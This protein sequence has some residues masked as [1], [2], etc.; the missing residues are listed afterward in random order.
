MQSRD[1][2]SSYDRLFVVLPL[3]AV[4]ACVPSR[5]LRARIGLV[6]AF[7]I[8]AAAALQAVRDARRRTTEQL[9]YAWL[10]PQLARLPAAC[11]LAWVDRAGRRT[12]M[13]GEYLARRPGDGPRALR[14]VEDASELP[15]GCVW[16]YRSSLCSSAE[17]RPICDAV[18]RPLGLSRLAEASFPAA[19]SYDGLDYDRPTVEVTLSRVDARGP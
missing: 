17:G 14:P 3:V 18:E 16:Y 4:T 8:V 5:W 13:L 7:A 2:Q 9:E 1:W 15:A 10:R 12:L 11:R 6:A 19:A